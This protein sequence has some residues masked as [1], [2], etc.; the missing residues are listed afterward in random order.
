MGRDVGQGTLLGRYA[1]E[2]L[3]G[4]GGMGAVHR[5]WD[6]ELLRHVALKVVRSRDENASGDERRAR[7]RLFREARAAAALDHPNAVRIYDVGEVD[8]VA[9]IAMELVTGKSLRSF[10][11]ANAPPLATRVAWLLDVARVLSVAHTRGLV[12]RDIK[13]DNV[14]VDTTG[15]IKVLD[16]GIARRTPHGEMQGLTTL[17][18]E[19]ALLGTP[20]YMS[21]EQLLGQTVDA[22]TDQFAWGSMAFEVLAGFSPWAGEGTIFALVARITSSPPP[23]L[24]ESVPG[25]PPLLEEVIF[26]ALAKEP[27]DRFATMDAL[28]LAL[29][30]AMAMLESSASEPAAP[31]GP[32]G[33]VQESAPERSGTR[34]RGE[35]LILTNSAFAFEG[36]LIIA[37]MNEKTPT[38]EEHDVM[39][40]VMRRVPAGQMKRTLTVT[41]GGGPTTMQRKRF[42]DVLAGHPLRAAIVIDKL[43]GRGIVTALSWYN[44]QI[45]A[46]APS[47]MD[48]ALEYLGVPPSDRPRVIEQV[49]FLEREVTK[50]A[51]GNRSR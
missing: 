1:I 22:R 34:P 43:A 9:F 3:I 31:M 38:N 49:A 21:P 7:Q 46:F 40:D 14:M 10:I 39:L 12:H 45:R 47:D 36:D 5:A 23:S 42:N 8:D 41:R 26:Q 32:A 51:R 20:S 24:R 50:A 35:L 37:F 30:P 15:A 19:G 11:G 4:V 29:A 13:P 6:T 18:E 16:F 27:S 28:A 17:T 48:R 44:P 2:E 25:I 33:R